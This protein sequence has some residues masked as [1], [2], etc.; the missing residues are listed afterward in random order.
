M[1][2]GALRMPNQLII[3]RHVVR[4]IAQ[5]HGL[6]AMFIAKPFADAPGS[7]MHIFQRFRHPEQGGDLLADP[8]CALS[9]WRIPIA[10]QLNHAVGM[11]LILVRHQF[12][13][14]A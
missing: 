7:G 14:T 4:T 2:T 1:P 6:R 13:Y 12:I 11:I 9:R 5:R 10:G 8:S 3:V